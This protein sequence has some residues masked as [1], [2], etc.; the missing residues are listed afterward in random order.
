MKAGALGALALI[1]A[2]A[3]VQAQ[4]DRYDALAK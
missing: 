1:C 3:Q 2:T 4:M